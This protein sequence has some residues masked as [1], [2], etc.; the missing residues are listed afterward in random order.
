V[1]AD[2]STARVTVTASAGCNWTATSNVSW[3]TITS[4]SSGSG[5]GTV[6][7]SVAANTSASARTGTLTIAGQTFTVT[8]QGVAAPTFQYDWIDTQNQAN[9]G[10]V[11][12]GA[13]IRLPDWTPGKSSAVQF[14]ITN[15][16]ASSQRVNSITVSGSAFRLTGVPTLPATLTT[17]APGV[18]TG[19]VIEFSP[20]AAGESSG[21]LTIDGSTF[22]LRASAQ[23]PV[24]TGVTIS[25]VSGTT[26]PTQR[27][28]V[29]VG[30]PRAYGVALTGTVSLGFTADAVNPMDDQ[31]VA[32]TGGGRTVNF[33]VAADGTQA[34]FSSGTANQF[35]TG[36]TAGRITVT[37]SVRAGSVD[38]TPSS[39]PSASVQIARGVP[40]ITNV[41]I[42]NR[43]TSGF[44]LHVTG[45]A[46]PREV[47]GATFQFSGSN[48]QTTSLTADAAVNT[49]FTKWYGGAESPPFGSSFKYVQAFMVSQGSV[50][51]ITSATVTLRNSLGNSTSASVNV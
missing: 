46:T 36:T 27:L 8:Q 42:V 37:V 24:V 10:T 41:A 16:S 6:N 2:A 13:T 9:R 12:P 3:I 31:T 1:G 48:L 7:Y 19:F 40:V 30:L 32:F 26:T 29:G 33:T 18:Q 39:A 22:Q 25:G 28:T 5:S 38:V 11:A 50:S 35:S 45:Y 43:T 44:E 4:G 34:I 23:F 49:A 51:S 21:T 14:F 15:R 20:S 17:T 47:T